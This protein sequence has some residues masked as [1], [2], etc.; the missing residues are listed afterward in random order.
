MTGYNL[1]ID[2]ESLHDLDTVFCA[3][4]NLLVTRI[5]D[6]GFDA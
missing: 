6:L 5:V 2:L 1:E 4:L 3:P